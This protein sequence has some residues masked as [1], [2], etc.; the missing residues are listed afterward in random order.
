MVE[1]SS[2]TQRQRLVLRL[3]PHVTLLAVDQVGHQLLVTLLRHT[4][5]DLQLLL[6]KEVAACLTFPDSRVVQAVVKD[7][8]PGTQAWHQV[9]PGYLETM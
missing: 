5:P 9:I 3:L 6:V 8:T 7:I 4:S 2:P 1:F